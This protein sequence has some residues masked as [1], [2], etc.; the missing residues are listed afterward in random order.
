MPLFTK[1]RRG[2]QRSRAS[3]HQLV[4]A[5]AV[6]VAFAQQRAVL[7]SPAKFIVLRCSGRA[8]KTRAFLLKWLQVKEDKPGEISAYVALTLESAMRLAWS[9]LKQ[10]DKELQLGL[11]FNIGKHTI[12]DSK[13]SQLVLLGANR[14]DLIDV[15]RGFP[16]VLVGFDEAAFFRGGLLEK[17]IDEAVLIRLADHDGDCWVM[18]TPGYVPSGYHHEICEGKKEGRRGWQFFHWDFFDN[19]HLPSERVAKRL[20]LDEAGKRQ[21]RE[22]YARQTREKK[23]WTETSPAYV[24]EFLG[25]PADDLGSLIY[26]VDRKRHCVQAMPE[27]FTTHRDSWVCV[28]GMDY[29]STNATAWVLWAFERGSADVYMVKA[30]KAYGLAP[31]VVADITRD[32]WIK[33]YQPEAFVG[34]PAAKAYID[35]LRVRCQISVESADKVDKR[36]HQRSMNDGFLFAPNPRIH[37]VE[38]ECEAY[39]D[40]AEKLGK[41]PRFGEQHHK[42]GAEDPGAENDCCDAGLYGYTRVYAWLEGLMVKLEADELAAK[43]EGAEID[44]ADQ[45]SLNRDD[46]YEYVL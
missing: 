27:S 40:E 44:P 23:G 28:L 10:M 42:Y 38:P 14:S 21:W 1:V 17:A 15:L 39:L 29:G 2:V 46:P 9:Q 6:T 19:P 37:I 3:A 12:T 18:S 30:R 41:D 24:R 20:G 26:K 4:A 36:A 8:G 25:L 5:L 31:S 22:D 43:Q 45:V 32:E 33:V 11:T 16:M 13:G 34:D 35:E 7:E